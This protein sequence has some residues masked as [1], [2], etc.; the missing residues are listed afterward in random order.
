[1]NE[2]LEAMKAEAKSCAHQVEEKKGLLSQ[3]HQHLMASQK[4][5]VKA[6]EIYEEAVNE[7]QR[8]EILREDEVIDEF[9][10][11]MGY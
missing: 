6:E 3:A 7:N 2:K 8:A 10:G 11:R 9:A 5:K 4:G 1:M